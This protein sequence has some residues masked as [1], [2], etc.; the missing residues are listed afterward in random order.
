MM[1]LF[2]AH[3]NVTDIFCS[4]MGEELSTHY[5]ATHESGY[6]P[7]RTFIHGKQSVLVYFLSG[8]IEQPIKIELF[9]TRN[10][11]LKNSFT[12]SGTRHDHGQIY[13]R[14]FEDNSHMYN[15]EI[16]KFSLHNQLE[17]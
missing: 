8:Q 5:I 11:A 17:S 7:G 12:F 3:V 10:N 2:T 13:C 1:L 6:S 14:I 16:H 15:P 9:Q 4:V